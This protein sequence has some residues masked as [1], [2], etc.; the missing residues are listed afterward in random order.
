MKYEKGFTLLQI[1]VGLAIA[2][3][4]ATAV[5]TAIPMMMQTAPR[6]ANKLGV[7]EDIAFFRYW[8]TRDANAADTFTTLSA[9]Y[10]GSLEWSD[11]RAES[12]VSYNVTYSYDSAT[13]SIIREERQDDVTQSSL[14][15]ARRILDPS[16]ATFTWSASTSKLTVDLTATIEDASGV[17]THS[18]DATI[19]TT[20]RHRAEP[21]VSPPGEEPVPPPPP[22]SETYYVASEPTIITGTL[23]SGN[24]TSLHDVD[25]DYYVVADTFKWASW[26]CESEEMTVPVTIAEIEVRWTGQASKKTIFVELFV[27]DSAA[28]FPVTAALSFTITE[29]GTDT[30]RSF[31]LDATALAYVNSLPER[32][33]TLMIEATL[34]SNFSL[35]TDKIMFIASP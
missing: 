27:K 9:P 5:M 31:Y 33:V 2:G 30:T 7:E 1:I 23:T 15:V 22:G 12:M 32:R 25:G 28:G 11:Y 17:G 35:F 13:T 24:L 8:L 20:L 14:P 4:L 19:V 26:W 3:M 16:D 10:F 34:G 29:S 21:A 18:R 6:Q